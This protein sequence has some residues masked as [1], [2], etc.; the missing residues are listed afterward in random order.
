MDVEVAAMLAH[1]VLLVPARLGAGHTL[2][3][4]MPDK[5]GNHGFTAGRRFSEN[6]L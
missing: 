4:G 3:T 5:A 1:T 2:V 6:P